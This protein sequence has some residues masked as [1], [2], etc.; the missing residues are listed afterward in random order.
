M[1]IRKFFSAPVF[2]DDEEKT[3]QAL[4]LQIILNTQ[5][6]VLALV[7]LGTTIT[8]FTTEGNRWP[9][10]VVMSIASLLIIFWRT[11]MERGQVTLASGGMIFFFTVSVTAI[12]FNGGT[13]RSTGLIY[14]PLSIVM[15]TLLI[16]RRAGLITF[17]FTSL[18]GVA[19]IEG[20]IRGLLPPANNQTTFAAH[21]I[22]I[23]G[24]G[25]ATVL[26]YLANRGTED[27]LTRA[28]RNEREVRELA[29]KL[30]VRVAE[31]TRDLTLSAEIGR[32]VV[33]ERNLDVLLPAAVERIR[34]T[35]ALYYA[36]IYLTD[37][38]GR[39]LILRAGSGTIGQELLQRGHRLPVASSSINGTAAFTKKAVLVED[40]TK[41]PTFL[42][43][44]LLP[45]TRSEM[46]VPLLSAEQVL[47]VLNMQS[48]FPDTFTQETLPAYEILAGQLAAAIENAY[49]F[50]EIEKARRQILAQSSLLTREGWNT[51]LDGVRQAEFVGVVY[52]QGETVPL[53]APV[54]SPEL[55]P[56]TIPIS[57]SGADIGFI[58]LESESNTLSPE[59]RDVAVRLADLAGQHLENLRLLAQAEHFRR[60]AEQ[61]ARRLTREGWDTYTQMAPAATDGF[62]YTNNRVKPLKTGQSETMPTISHALTL[63]GEAIGTLHIVPP[64]GESALDAETAD[65]ITTVSEAL[66]AHLENLRLTSAT[67][68]ALAQ[69]ERQ[70]RSL[71]RLNEMSTALNQATHL[72]QLIALTLQEA[73]LILSADV[74]GLAL[75]TPD[76][77]FM[78][79]FRLQNGQVIQVVAPEG[80]L[81]PLAN[82][83]AEKVMQERRILLV[84]DARQ[85]PLLDLK[86]MART[87]MVAVM[88][89]PLVLGTQVLG[90]LNVMS[91]SPHRQFTEQDANLLQQVA[92][93]VATTLENQRLLT[94][95]TKRAEHE[96]LINTINQRIQSAGSVET[97]LETAAREIGHLLK[98]RRAVVEIGNLHLDKTGINEHFS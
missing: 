36:Q 1:D 83:S 23:S 37:A 49:Q 58:Q 27:A 41:S 4:L 38:A 26:L 98:A 14:F 97:A 47:G 21:A 78:E 10:L 32:T 42:P 2:K 80:K 12:L 96:A 53:A 51:Y 48:E 31:R 18:I 91:F 85:S 30:E 24:L 5:V 29:T 67:E 20:E 17:F 43:N 28:R 25:L 70:A 16:G 84:P 6:G 39:T 22:I 95:T 88:Q 34:Q 56:L 60:E 50:A 7:I 59:E 79:A 11:L 35:F 90:V 52:Q 61:A 57:I 19:L 13:L 73:P 77:Q 9:E 69:T 71:S 93:V 54:V 76:K 3:R 55:G 44:P 15:A 81:I 94:Q 62:V 63:R 45:K 82:T 46:S 89:A 87:G 72:I 92:L 68:T 64:A 66:T 8:L 74:A 86:D 40:T 65:L 75:L 33:Q